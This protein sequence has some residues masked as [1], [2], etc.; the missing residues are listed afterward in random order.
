[1]ITAVIDLADF[2]RARLDDDERTAGRCCYTDQPWIG[3][4]DY[5]G[6]HYLGLSCAR[7]LADVQAKRRIVRLHGA[8]G[9][10]AGCCD[11]GGRGGPEGI[12][13]TTLAYLALPYA[14][15]P[16]YDEAWRP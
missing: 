6:A 4:V 2:L 16:D 12:G 13:C 1:M 8:C 10:G 5:R 11:D 3:L 15:H 14:D 9:T 7:I